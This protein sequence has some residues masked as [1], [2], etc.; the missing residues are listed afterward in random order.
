[1]KDV[2]RILRSTFYCATDAKEST[3]TGTLTARNNTLKQGDGLNN[4]RHNQNDR[5]HNKRARHHIRQRQQ[6]HRI[7]RTRILTPS[8]TRKETT[9]TLPER[10]QHV[11]TIQRQ[12]RNQI[13]RKKHQ[14]HIRHQRDQ[15][16]CLRLHINTVS[17]RHL[18][19][20]TTHTNHRHRRLNTTLT[21]SHQSHRQLP[22]TLRQ[23]KHR[24]THTRERIAHHRRHLSNRT[25]HQLTRRRNTHKTAASRRN[26][27]IRSTRILALTIRN[28]ANHLNR[29]HRQIQTLTI[30]LHRQST[31]VRTRR[32]NRRRHSLP[33][34]RRC[35]IHSN[36]TVTH[37]H[38]SSL[39]RRRSGLISTFAIANRIMSDIH[40]RHALRHRRHLIRHLSR[41]KT[42]NQ[43]SST[44]HTNQQVH[45]RAAQHNH[46]ALEHRQL[47]EKAVLITGL[48]AL[49]IRRTRLLSHG[50]KRAGTARMALLMVLLHL[51][52]AR[53]VHA[54]HRNVTAQ[55][56]RLETVLSLA[57]AEREH[58]L[59]EANHVL[60]NAHIK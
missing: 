59:T 7:K 17:S 41:T 30:T 40:A 34:T 8:Q 48:H 18:T 10:T 24:R 49:S 13:K 28:R 19:G 11:A 9:H 29:S 20:N 2:R 57:A 27:T 54:N 36:H 56:D 33:R 32:T 31:R 4:I 14:I 6:L 44:H 37:L 15:H 5:H 23:R 51:S 26:R 60:R 38:T 46:H 1:M 55:R 22:H 12:K 52:R 53:R 47:I 43:H 42:T 35:T 50:R 58:G 21:T 3:N 16:R 39:R 25:R 45:G